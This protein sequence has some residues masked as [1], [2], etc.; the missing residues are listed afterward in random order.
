MIRTVI[1]GLAAVLPALAASEEM[2]PQ[3]RE[4]SLPLPESILDLPKLRSE[5][6]VVWQPTGWE[7]LTYCHSPMIGHWRGSVFV[8]WHATKRGEHSP[9]YV[10]LVSSSHDL[11]QWAPAARYTANGD[12]GYREYMRKRYGFGAD[13]PLVVNVAARALHPTPGRLYLWTLAW[14]TRQEDE[15]NRKRKY[16]GRVHWT[17]DGV[18]WHEI[19]PTE[20][21]RR[22]REAGLLK[23]IRDAA[24]NRSFIR[25][26]DG[27]IM[28]AAMGPKIHTPITRDPS[29][30]SGWAG[31]SIDGTA[32]ARV[33]E[34]HG[35]QGPDRALHFVS[36]HLGPHVWHAYSID[37]GRT[38]SKL[39][40]QRQFTDSPANKQ[41]GRLPDGRIWYLGNPLP[42]T[43]RTHLVLG[44]SRDGWRFDRPYLVRWE[45][46]AQRYPAPHKGGAPG[47]EY[48]AGCTHDGKLCVVYAHARDYIE[49]AVVGLDQLG[50][51]GHGE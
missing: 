7:D 31:G 47:Y 6:H 39:R 9:Q 44:V 15:T 28:A 17:G 41:F 20:L 14:V 43:T 18:R 34:P 5:R 37:A 49:L 23:T 21:D 45:P 51:S 8:A 24:S 46:W 4:I 3:H 50:G 2:A 35:Y 48:P 13:D 16:A 1:V 36:R 19:P 10:A 30:L 27:R 26:S 25:L 42:H 38:W 11:K 33:W 40:E 32:A 12:D 22:E 29:G